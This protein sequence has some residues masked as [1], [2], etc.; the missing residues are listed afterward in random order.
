MKKL[1]LACAILFT[2]WGGLQAQ[3]TPNCSQGEKL[4][5]NTWEKWGP[6][7]PNISLVP[8]KNGITQIKQHWNWIASN[9]TG[10]IGPRRLDIGEGNE[11][12]NILGQ[13][14]STFVTSPSFNDN[15]EITINKYDGRAETGVTICTHSQSGVTATVSSYVFPNGNNGQTKKFTIANA[16]GKIISIAMKNNSAGNQF[17][18]RI[19]AD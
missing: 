3:N 15:V 4:A 18:Y 19:K 8:F 12:G 13:T 16:K 1:V 7:K 5:E 6:W 10:T 17:K 11:Q 9:G 14:K 2:F